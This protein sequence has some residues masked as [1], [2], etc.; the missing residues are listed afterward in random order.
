M[1]EQ[2]SPCASACGLPLLLPVAAAHGAVAP[3][4]RSS[5]DKPPYQPIQR[6]HSCKEAPHKATCN[7]QTVLLCTRTLH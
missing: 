5:Y 7:N 2:A 3:S 6:R 4:T 1:S